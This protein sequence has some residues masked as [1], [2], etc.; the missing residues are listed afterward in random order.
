MTINLVEAAKAAG[1]TLEGICSSLQICVITGSTNEVVVAN[2]LPI[3][4]ELVTTN[5][6]LR[7]ECTMQSTGTLIADFLAEVPNCRIRLKSHLSA[8]TTGSCGR[9]RSLLYGGIVCQCQLLDGFERQ[10]G[11]AN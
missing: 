2:H 3:P 9:R 4:R 6:C 5:E 7:D 11:F 10:S 1:E 8:N